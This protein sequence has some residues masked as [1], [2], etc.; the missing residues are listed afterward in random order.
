[1]LQRTTK[2]TD[3][4]DE[5]PFDPL[6]A[7]AHRRRVPDVNNSVQHHLTSTIA[8]DACS[9]REPPPPLRWEAT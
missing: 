2:D 4:A 8:S 5:G 6:A 1:M 9:Q 7:Y 3:K